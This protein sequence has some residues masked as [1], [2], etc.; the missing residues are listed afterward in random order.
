[1]PMCCGVRVARPVMHHRLVGRRRLISY[2]EIGHLD[3]SSSLGPALAAHRKGVYVFRVSIS[4]AQIRAFLHRLAVAVGDDRVFVTR[5]AA[6]E[7]AEEL[8]FDRVTIL[9]TLAE[10][11]VR[12]FSHVVAST[13]VPDVRVWVFTP[14][15]ESM[16]LWIR[17]VERTGM[18]V[19]SFHEA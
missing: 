14:E 17:L 8:G 11:E 4:R 19:V 9:N 12:D 6:Q 13:A 16:T 18:V 1:M 10:L 7:A 5:K 3:T 2:D 15:T